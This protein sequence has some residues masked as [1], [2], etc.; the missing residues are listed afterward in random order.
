[1]KLPSQ[2]STRAV[3]RGL[4]STHESPATTIQRTR[5][6]V[7]TR[8]HPRNGRDPHGSSCV[9][10]KKRASIRGFKTIV[11]VTTATLSPIYFHHRPPKCHV[12]GRDVF[13]PC[14]FPPPNVRNTPVR[15]SVT[16]MNAQIKDSTARKR[17]LE[18]PHPGAYPGA[19]PVVPFFAQ[20][21]L[22]PGI[23]L[24]RKMRAQIRGCPAAP[25]LSLTGS[26]PRVPFGFTR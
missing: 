21:A 20:P 5:V 13:P 8:D 25:P 7:F 18:P 22:A 26:I 6:H 2:S 9:S 23:F 15:T 17:I 19:S 1:M 24:E 11:A 12:N 10:F 14:V 16:Q 3:Q 4:I